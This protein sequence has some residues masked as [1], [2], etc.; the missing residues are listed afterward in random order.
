MTE[1]EARLVLLLRAFETP[2]GSGW[3]EADAAWASREAL[4]VEGERSD[5]EGFLARRAALGSARLARHEAPVD[6]ALRRT[7][8]RAWVA[9]G[10]VLVAFA[11][12]F[13]SESL[14]AS[15]RINILAPPLLAVLA[16]NLAVYAAL[17]LGVFRRLGRATTSALHDAPSLGP[18]RQAMLRLIYRFPAGAK[19]IGEEHARGGPQA[20]SSHAS[21][22][23][24]RFVLDWNRARLPVLVER[25][26]TVMHVAA[27]AFAIGALLSMYL[28]GL[29][30]EYRAG[31]EST[32]LTPQS[33]HQIVSVVLGP[34]SRSS[35][36]P[37]PGEAEL[38]GLAFSAGPGENA[39]RWIHLYALTL[40]LVVV[41]PRALLAAW[42]GWRARRLE[43]RLPL[44]LDDDYFRRLRRVHSGKAASVFVLP[45]SYHLPPA[46]LPKLDAVFDRWLGPGVALTLAPPVAIAGEDE[47]LP[48]PPPSALPDT[49]LVALFP[50]TATPERETHGA[51]LRAL[52][53]ALSRAGAERGRLVVM[54]DESAFRQRFAGTDAGARLS[55]RRTAW[56]R[57]LHDE[58]LAPMCVDLAAA[59]PGSD[60]GGAAGIASQ[61]TPGV[62][63]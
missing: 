2:P 22:A 25:L 20:A 17:A 7:G 41:L 58:G 15:Q 56:E 39:A 35:G 43:R 9:W 11:V 6:A 40:G 44:A 30:F 50:L 63:P 21:A 32:F 60:A 61:A 4:R 37:L 54:L 16:W 33:V 29:A 38:A 36:I 5:F 19:A 8:A 24:G 42:A 10:A 3:N 27:I 52:A 49:T 13:S 1:S 46:L 34:A 23:L 57:M 62:A 28:R 12:G 47:A 55:Q 53:E 45:Y 31:W 26:T 59:V 18:L 51:F 48:L 14:G